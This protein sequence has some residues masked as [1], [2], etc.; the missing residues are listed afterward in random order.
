NLLGSASA[1]YG[2]VATLNLTGLTAGQSYYVVA[3]GATSDVFGMG[4]YVLG[5]QFSTGPAG[6]VPLAPSNLTATAAS[7]SRVDLTW[8]DNASNESGFQIQ[9]SLD[10]TTFTPAGT[11]PADATGFSVT[12]LAASTTYYFRVRASNAAGDSAW[13]NT[14]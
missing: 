6:S 12:G 7:D 4:A 14:T 13:S 5:V 2:G 3:D 10:G 1:A 8:L 11:A 9:Q